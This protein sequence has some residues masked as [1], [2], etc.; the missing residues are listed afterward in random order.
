MHPGQTSLLR[1]QTA[2]VN[3]AATAYS[4]LDD[5]RLIHYFN[6]VR[7]S[8]AACCTASAH[9]LQLTAQVPLGFIADLYPPDPGWT[10]LDDWT[11]EQSVRFKSF[12]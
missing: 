3:A 12:Q 10:T 8:C 11:E 6:Y 2:F 5:R 7:W 4:L 9:W 1:M